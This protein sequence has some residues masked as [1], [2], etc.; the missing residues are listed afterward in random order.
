MLDFNTTPLF[1]NHQQL[2]QFIIVLTRN[3]IFEIETFA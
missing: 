3:D 1:A 2:P